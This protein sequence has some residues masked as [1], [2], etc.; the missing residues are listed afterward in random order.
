[1]ALHAGFRLPSGAVNRMYNN[2][3]L[4]VDMQP[5]NKA[6]DAVNMMEY[7]CMHGK[8]GLMLMA[9]SRLNLFSL[10]NYV[11]GNAYNVN[12][13]LFRKIKVNEDY[14]FFPR[15]GAVYERAQKDSWMNDKLNGS[16]GQ[17]LMA[18]VGLDLFSGSFS[19]GFAYQ[20]AIFNR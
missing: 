4:D 17:V 19:L 13:Y 9:S 2:Q 6:F 12:A 7:V 16:G 15:M 1:M 8:N 10:T 20:N 18:D 3:L 14:A 11:Y 5:G